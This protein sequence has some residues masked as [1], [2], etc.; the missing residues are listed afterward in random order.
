MS[1]D[2]IAIPVPPKPKPVDPIR[3]AEALAKL[4]ALPEPPPP[5]T[6]D[7]AAPLSA[8]VEALLRAKIERMED[9]LAS[10]QDVSVIDIA[11]L[12]EQVTG[13][14]APR[15]DAEDFDLAKLTDA[16]A[17]ELKRLLDKARK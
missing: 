14:T 11:R 16:E 3:G 13:K 4:D 1:G 9:A 2:H 7:R 15:D 17:W 6:P 10:N 8:R 5:F 12:A